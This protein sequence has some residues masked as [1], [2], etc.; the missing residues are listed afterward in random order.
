MLDIVEKGPYVPMYQPLKN[1]VPDGT[2]KK[3]PRENWTADDKRKH[4]LDV[5]ARAAISYSLP[6]NIFGLVQ[7]YSDTENDSDTDSSKT[8][9][10]DL[11]KVVASA[12]L[13][14]KTFEK[15]GRNFSKFQKKIGGKFSKGSGADKK[16]ELLS[17]PFDESP[18]AEEKSDSTDPIIPVP[19]SLSQ[20]TAA[21]ST[22][23][24]LDADDSIEAEDSPE[25]DNVSVSIPP[26][27]ASVIMDVK[28]TFLHGVLEEEVFLNQPLGFV[29]KD[30]PDYVY[31]LDKAV[32][33]LKQAP[34][35]WYE[36]LTSYLL[37]NGYKRGA[38]DNTLFIKGKGS[39]MHVTLVT[40]SSALPQTLIVASP[41]DNG[42][43]IQRLLYTL[44]GCYDAPF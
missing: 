9:T 21:T 33:G 12:A 6:Y 34:R 11:E 24:P 42:S 36:T 43:F 32:Y 40:L 28:T 37:E 8:D 26:E 35:V 18:C 13:I 15:S 22:D 31:R 25:T 44:T 41:S 19:C 39:D 29:D 27:S 3:T 2:M 7:N 5:R 4:G 23:N 10:D 1:N 17:C 14:V 20:D 30:H 16:H 38:I